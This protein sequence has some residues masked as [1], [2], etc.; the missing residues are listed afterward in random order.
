MR[1]V[2]LS[3]V[4]LHYPPLLS[5]S[6]SLLAPP[7]P[8]LSNLCPFIMSI[9]CLIISSFFSFSLYPL[10]LLIH[11]SPPISPPFP[12]LTTS[13]FFF[14]F[15]SPLG[16]LDYLPPEMVEGRDHDSTGK[17]GQI[18]LFTIYLVC[19]DMLSSPYSVCT[20]YC[21]MYTCDSMLCIIQC[22]IFDIYRLCMISAC[23]E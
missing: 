18:Y 5:S 12:P 23:I 14:S 13:S 1:Y 17:P 6:P 16:T 10:P 15:L 2:T 3:Q 11:P 19:D 9:P 8:P 21:F 20:F 4:L 22:A 7:P